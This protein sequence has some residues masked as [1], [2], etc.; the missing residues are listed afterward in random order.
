MERLLS[1]SHREGDVL[2][3]HGS[4]RNHLRGYVLPE[5]IYNERK[6]SEIETQRQ[7]D[8]PIS[9]SLGDLASRRDGLV[10]I[11]TWSN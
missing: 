2:Y 6:M 9:G 5:D 4:P 8:V 10:R 11:G 7:S 3:V 1:P